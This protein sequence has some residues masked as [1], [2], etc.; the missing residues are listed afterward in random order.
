MREELYK[1]ETK[2]KVNFTMVNTD[3]LFEL[4]KQFLNFIVHFGKFL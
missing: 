3:N 2:F 1:Q 4:I